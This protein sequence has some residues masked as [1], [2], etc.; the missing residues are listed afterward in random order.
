MKRTAR[1]AA[2]AG[3]LSLSPI[4]AGQVS[5]DP[6][7]PYSP[8]I[9]GF[10]LVAWSQQQNPQPVPQPLSHPVEHERGQQPKLPACPP[11]PQP[12]CQPSTA[13]NHG[14]SRDACHTSHNR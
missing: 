13:E 4:V 1:L 11:A 6:V 10:D 8:D 5:Q 2:I 3:A 7:L 14:R 9:F 12:L